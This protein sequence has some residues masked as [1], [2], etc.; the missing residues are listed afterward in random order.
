[1]PALCRFYDHINI[2]IIIMIDG[3]VGGGGGVP[4]CRASFLKRWLCWQAGVIEAPVKATNDVAPQQASKDATTAA[5]NQLPE[6]LT[7]GSAYQLVLRAVAQQHPS[8]RHDP[9]TPVTDESC[10]DAASSTFVQQAHPVTRASPSAQQTAGS[11]T[12][13]VHASGGEGSDRQQKGLPRQGSVFARIF[14]GRRQ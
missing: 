9:Q 10:A 12:K 5:A 3:G 2:I 7:D 6:G 1:M 14:K 13:G 4:N 11:R 8:A